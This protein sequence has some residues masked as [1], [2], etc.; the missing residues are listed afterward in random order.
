M[1]TLLVLACIMHTD[2]CRVLPVASGLVSNRQCMAYSSLMIDGWKA[3]NPE[4]MVQR[5]ICTENP[6]FI[7]GAWQT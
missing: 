1:I 6:E 3:R 4:S 7:I 2:D 5:W